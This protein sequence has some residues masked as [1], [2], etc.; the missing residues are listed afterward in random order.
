M[1]ASNAGTWNAEAGVWV[2]DRAIG[3]DIAVPKPLVIFGYGSLCWRPDTTLEAFESFP[4][5][6]RGWTRLFAQRSTDHRGTPEFPG[7]VATICEVSALESLPGFDAA[8]TADS[9]LGRAYVVPD[10]EATKVLAELDFR[11]KGGYTR[12]VVE[13][14]CQRSGDT[15]NALLYSGTV[16]NPNFWWGDDGCGLDLDRAAAIVAS[17][18]GPSGP[19]VDYLRN[20][21]AFLDAE[22]HSDSH[23]SDLEKRVDALLS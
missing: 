14:T 6:I 3:G 10:D 21:S 22:G 16:D 5:L 7:L 2:G 17:A 18:V 11:E 13:V 15:V 1:A 4:C 12:R 20:L 19:N 9:T 8:S 23:V